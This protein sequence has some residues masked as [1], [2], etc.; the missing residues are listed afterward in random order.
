MKMYILILDTV[1]DNFVPVM[2]A[3][4]S[5]LNYLEYKNDE[6]MVEWVHDSFKKVTCRVTQEQFDKAMT[7]EDRYT[8]TTE[9]NLDNMVCTVTFCPREEWHWW[10]KT[11]PLWTPKQEK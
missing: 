7:L 10:F 8:I 3:H 1:P 6:E 4:S 11:I 2:T 9:S 5:L